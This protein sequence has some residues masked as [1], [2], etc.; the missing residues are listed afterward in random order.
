MTTYDRISRFNHWTAAILFIVMLGFGFYLAYGGVPMPEKL[1]MIAKHK[2]IGVLL[3]VWGAWRVG[4]R[5]KQ[6][7][8]LPVAPLPNWQEVASKASHIILLASVLLMPMS[9]LTM[10]LYSG[11]PT[12]VFGLFTIPA[13]DKVDAI[14]GPAR[15]AH[16]YIAYAFTL[17]LGMHIAAA[18]KHHFL[19]K[20]TTFSRMIKG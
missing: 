6:G 10:A 11:F 12:D 14:A 15:I 18:L 7:F 5:I 4:Y 17:T 8:A 20:D 1:P 9:G 13:I 2:A 19:D 3:L 16:K